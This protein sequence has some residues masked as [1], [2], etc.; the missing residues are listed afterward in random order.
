[1]CAICVTATIAGE[2]ETA[3]SVTVARKLRDTSAGIFHVYAHCVWATSRLFRD[4]A[5]RMTFLR[6]LARTTSKLSWTCIG[7]CLMQSHYHLIVDVDSGVLPDAMH[8]L[9]FRYAC[10]FNQR[11]AMRGHC[12]GARYDSPRIQSEEHLLTAYRYVMRNPVEAGLCERPQEWQWSSYS[13][14]IGLVDP[15]GFVDPATVLA[16]FGAA[17]PEEA[18]FRLRRFVEDS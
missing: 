16:C 8:A 10:V 15:I 17:T 9:N 13:A 3:S 5:D 11:H 7:Y 12:F 14:A 4:D 6:E 18:V 1:M 2:R